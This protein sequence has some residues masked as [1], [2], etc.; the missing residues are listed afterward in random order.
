M[1]SPELL[2]RAYLQHTSGPGGRSGSCRATQ[3]PLTSLLPANYLS[4]LSRQKPRHSRLLPTT[5]LE[6]FSFG[7]SH[8]PLNCICS[9][10]NKCTQRRSQPSN[11]C[12]SPFPNPLRT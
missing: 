3:R 2:K 6:T 7:P 8:Q 12:A 1:L 5:R 4:T 9:V 11:L 10:C